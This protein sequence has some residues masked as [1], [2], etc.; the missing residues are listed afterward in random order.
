MSPTGRPSR[1]S[2]LSLAAVLGAAPL[3]GACARI[4]T[5]SPIA[6][7]PAPGGDVGGAPYVQPR[8]PIDG[9]SPAEIVAGFVQA[10]VGAEDD[11]AIARRYLTSEAAAAWDPTMQV[12]VY[13]A[14][15]E[16]T[17]QETD[18]DLVVLGVQVIASVD[19]RGVRTRFGTPSPR[20]QDVSLQ[21]VHGQW[22]ISEPPDGI[23]LS[24]A[25]FT[26]LFTGV[27][28]YFLDRSEKHLVPEVRWFP[29]RRVV[30]EA[31]TEL[32]HGPGPVLQSAVHSALP[33]SFVVEDDDVTTSDDGA[34]EITLPGALAAL[35]AKRRALALRQV[36]SSLESVHALGETR[37]LSD[38][39]VLTPDASHG[40]ARPLP[41]HR[42]YGAGHTGVIAL[43]DSPDGAAPTQLVPALAELELRGP[44]LSA[45][46]ALAAAVGPTGAVLI[47]STDG[48]IGLREAAVGSKLVAPTLDEAGRVWTSPR[49]NTGA[50]LAL[51]AAGA[52]HD[53]KVL[54]PWLTGREVLSLHAAPDAT[55][56]LVLSATGDAVSLDLCA[57]VRDEDDR[58]T[59]VSAPHTIISSLD[60]ITSAGWYDET[61][62]ILL[63]EAPNDSGPRA[64]VLDAV[65]GEDLLPIPRSGTDALAGTAVADATWATTSGGALL[66]S[67]GVTWATVD[68]EARDPAFY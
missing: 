54:A 5:S 66:R 51:S 56:L 46:G 32:G 29:S 1:R 25:A 61:A 62:V 23:Y 4:P 55:R 13:S 15:Q 11:Y 60:R 27:R 19:R 59:A 21:K 49:R 17:T 33:S 10:G 24:D 16:I 36:S 63:G 12:T 22:R 45:T 35:S 64:L 39:R 37:L 20:E 52:R 8:P 41:G 65:T 31:L 44:A 6:R 40:P 43:D 67:D 34:V 9:A 53:A 47:A 38:G 28:L 58:P 50:L 48:S 18:D 2:L 30:S 68:L 42:P 26:L 14:D 3:L 57:I 7:T